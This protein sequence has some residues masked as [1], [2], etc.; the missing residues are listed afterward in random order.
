MLSLLLAVTLMIPAD[1]AEVP[2]L[3]GPQQRFFAS[4]D[5]ERRANAGDAVYRAR[6]VEI[7]WHP[8]PVTFVWDDIKTRK[9]RIRFRI[10]READGVCVC[11]TNFLYLTTGRFGWDNFRVGTA[12]RWCLDV[13]GKG[14]ATNRFVTAETPP[15]LVRVPGVPNLR[16]LGGWRTRDGRRVRQGLLYRSANLCENA[17]ECVERPPRTRLTPATTLY[18]TD[19]LGIRTELD[20]RGPKECEGLVASPLGSGVR[21]VEV[22]SGCYGQMKE[23]WAREACLKDLRLVAD[24]GNLPLLFHCSSGQDRTGTLAFLVNGILGVSADDLA[25]DWDA[26]MLWNNEH[27]WFNR[28]GSYAA[29]LKVMDA[30]P[31]A[32]LND[33]IVA[34]VKSLGFTEQEIAALRELYLEMP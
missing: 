33:R 1:R 28:N 13:A 7:G 16:D 3:T 29:L 6:L 32:T 34:Y 11:D 18:M 19:A 21:R 5:E 12:Y 31:G 10:W 23:S 14:S 15:R 30:Y 26:T 22:S 27:S 8:Q 25:R 17:K 20:L 24:A 4:S 9:E 2:V